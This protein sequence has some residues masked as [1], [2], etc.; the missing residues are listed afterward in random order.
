MNRERKT[1][2]KKT[3]ESIKALIEEGHKAKQS[4]KNL[5]SML[6]SSHETQKLSLDEIVDDYKSFYMAGKETSATSLGW[7]LFLLGLNQEWQ[8][9]AREEVLRILGPNTLPT[10][11]ILSELK[12]VSLYLFTSTFFS[13]HKLN[14]LVHIVNKIIF[15]LILYIFKK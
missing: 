4:S 15:V 6:M 14:K 9:K 7:A 13:Q 11:E 1:L 5:L 10:S 3:Y 8:S 2:E 12:L